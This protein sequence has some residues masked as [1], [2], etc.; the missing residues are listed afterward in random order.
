LKIEETQGVVVV[1]VEAD[2]RSYEAGVKIGDVVREMDR[3]R[4][5]NIQDFKEATASLKGDVLV[6]AERGYIIVKE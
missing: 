4:I 1:N 5:A 3:R 6:R 2:S